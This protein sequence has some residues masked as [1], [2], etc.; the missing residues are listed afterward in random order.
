MSDTAS[1][2]IN[3]I[4]ASRGETATPTT[5]TPQAPD[6]LERAI[7][8]R[9]EAP[10]SPL[11]LRIAARDAEARNVTTPALNERVAARD[12][13]DSGVSSLNERIAA[14]EA[15][16]VTETKAATITAKAQDKVNNFGGKTPSPEEAQPQRSMEQAVQEKAQKLGLEKPVP[17]NMSDVGDESIFR[18]IADIPIKTGQG[19]VMGVRMIA[20]A[21]GADNELSQ[22]LRG[23]EDYLGALVSAQSKED[24]A[25]VSRIM[26]EAKNKGVWEQL[27]AGAEA[28]AV[29]PIDLLSN[30]FGTS[31]PIILAGMATVA[32]GGGTVAVGASGVALGGLTGVGV[33]KGSIYDAT[34]EVLLEQGKVTPEQ[35]EKMAVEAQAY[36]GENLDMILTGGALGILASRSGIE[37]G[38]I[39][40]MGKKLAQ[41]LGKEVSRDIAE[42]T[43]KEGGKSVAKRSALKNIT[44]ETVTEAAQ[45]SHEQLSANVAKNRIGIDTPLME[46]VVSSG[47]LEG[48]GGLGVSGVA[49]AKNI[50]GKT[51][52]KSVLNLDKK[53]K[54]RD[55]KK[56]EAVANGE[57]PAPAGTIKQELKNLK[58]DVVEK[59]SKA[60]QT[61]TSQKKAV[62]ALKEPA[63]VAEALQPDNEKFT[64]EEKV[65][66]AT[67]KSRR[68]AA[69][70]SPE[71]IQK[72]QGEVQNALVGWYTEVHT[73]FNELVAKSPKEERSP[74]DQKRVNELFEIKREI[75]AKIKNIIE[76]A[77]D[78]SK[79]LKDFTNAVDDVKKN[80][81]PPDA[82]VRI[83]G[84][85][86][87]KNIPNADLKSLQESDIKLP[88]REKAI[89]DTQIEI[90]NKVEAL[91]KR[92]TSTKSSDYVHMEVVNGTEDNLG[93]KNYLDNI[94]ISV[95]SQ[96]TTTVK[97]SVG[98]F[99]KF[100]K[101]H[102]DKAVD[103]ANTIKLDNANEKSNT[104]ESK[105]ALDKSVELLKT[106]Y[107]WDHEFAGATMNVL[108]LIKDEVAIGEAY[109]TQIQNVVNTGAKS[110]A[111]PTST[112]NTVI[113]DTV[114]SQEEFEQS[115][116]EAPLPTPDD[117]AG[118][119]GQDAPLG[120]SAGVTSP[121]SEV[122][123]NQSP[124]DNAGTS[125]LET[126]S[127]SEASLAESNKTGS[128][129]EDE[130]SLSEGLKTELKES[131][132][133]LKEN[134]EN[135]G[136]ITPQQE[137]LLK[138]SEKRINGLTDTSLKQRLV[139][140][141]T[142]TATAT[143]T[144]NGAT[145]T[146]TRP[147]KKRAEGQNNRLREFY[148][149]IE[150]V[151]KARKAIAKKQGRRKVTQYTPIEAVTNAII[152]SGKK[153]VMSKK[154]AYD[155]INNKP[156]NKEI[157]GLFVSEKA[158]SKMNP[159]S[160]IDA[161]DNLEPDIFRDA[162]IEPEMDGN[163]VKASWLAKVFNEGTFDV[164]EGSELAADRVVEEEIKRIEEF[165][166]VTVGTDVDAPSVDIIE[167]FRNYD[168]NLEGV[169]QEEAS[170]EEDDA[171]VQEDSLRESDGTNK[172]SDTTLQDRLMEDTGALF[173]S[174][175]G[176]PVHVKDNHLKKLFKVKELKNSLN[177]VLH[178]IVSWAEN[179]TEVNSK[180]N[181]EEKAM[182][183][184][185]IAFDKGINRIL[186]QGTFT[187]ED[188][189]TTQTHSPLLAANEGRALAFKND[190][191][192]NFFYNKEY[193]KENPDTD[194]P[195]L[196]PNMVTAMSSVLY[197]WLA[198]HG[199]G[200][201]SMD[202]TTV[203]RTIMG[204]GNSKITP[205]KEMF[206]L[207]GDKGTNQSLLAEQLGT[208]LISSLGLSVSENNP[209][210]YV[211][212]AAV[213][214]GNVILAAGFQ[215]GMIE[216]T[217]VFT[218]DVNKLKEEYRLAVKEA[219]GT[220]KKVDNE[221]FDEGDENSDFTDFTDLSE[222]AAEGQVFYV[223]V[224]PHTVETKLGSKI[225][226]SP[227]IQDIRKKYKGGQRAFHNLFGSVSP[228]RAPSFEKPKE[229]TV[230]PTIKKTDLNVA[231]E[232]QEILHKKAQEPHQ[233]SDS[234]GVIKDFSDAELF[235]LFGGI[236]DVDKKQIKLQA[237]YNA[238]NTE[239]N[240]F[241]EDMR[242]FIDGAPKDDS[243]NL[244]KDFYYDYEIWRNS[245]IGMKNN[246]MNYQSSKLA[247]QLVALKS[248]KV[249]IPTVNEDSNNTDM[250]EILTLFHMAVAQGMGIDEGLSSNEI[251][252][253]LEELMS[254]KGL[255]GGIIDL[256]VQQEQ[257]Y[258]L[259]PKDRARLIKAT[260]KGGLHKISA[261]TAWA[262]Y[263]QAKETGSSFSTNL[264]RE[265]DGKVNG[266]AHASFQSTFDQEGNP[267]RTNFMNK[268][269]I[270]RNK[271][272][273]KTSN[274]YFNDPKNKDVYQDVATVVGANVTEAGNKL[275]KDP[276]KARAYQVHQGA[277]GLVGSFFEVIDG[278]NTDTVTKDGREF[279]KD[280]VI[281]F[282]YGAEIS[283][284]TSGVVAV[285]MNKLYTDIENTLG[286][287]AKLKIINNS[288][289]NI[290]GKDAKLNSDNY[291]TY[292]LNNVS[293]TAER[294][295]REALANTYKE[296]LRAALNDTFWQIKAAKKKIVEAHQFAYE[297]F[298]GAYYTKAA[299][300]LIGNNGQPLT[301]KQE[302][303]ILK[304]LAPLLP[305]I[306]TAI[307]DN[308]GKSGAYLWTKELTKDYDRV[309][310]QKQ[311][312]ALENS[313]RDPAEIKIFVAALKKGYKKLKSN[314][315]TRNEFFARGSKE[316]IRNTGYESRLNK[317][318]ED[319]VGKLAGFARHY[320]IFESTN[321][322]FVN[323]IH[324]LDS[325]NMLEIYAELEAM[326]IHDAIMVPLN[327]EIK[328]VAF[329]NQ[330]FLKVNNNYNLRAESINR[331]E[332]T[333][334][335]YEKL[336][337]NKNNKKIPYGVVVT[338]ARIAA[339]KAWMNEGAK[340]S[341]FGPKKQAAA[342][343]KTIQKDV[344]NLAKNGLVDQFQAN[345][346]SYS[347]N[348]DGVAQGESI[349]TKDLDKATAK[350]QEKLEKKVD[351]D[352]AIGIITEFRRIG[353][354]TKAGIKTSDQSAD[355]QIY[356]GI[357]KQDLKQ[358]V[359]VLKSSEEGKDFLA[360]DFDSFLG[361]GPSDYDENNFNPNK[362]WE[363]NGQG[364]LDLF[365]ML[366]TKGFGNKPE[367]AEHSKYLRDL[368]VSFGVTESI[369]N[370][371]IKLEET[372]TES[373]GY[374]VTR[375]NGKKEIHMLSASKASANGIRMSVQETYAHELLHILSESVINTS[376]KARAELDRLFNE[377]R[378]DPTVD[379]RA[380]LND[381][382]D[383]SNQAE[384]D[385]AKARYDYIFENTETRQE[386][387]RDDSTGEIHTHDRN[388]FLHEFFALGLSNENFVKALAGRFSTKETKP[389]NK[390]LYDKVVHILVKTMG[391]FDKKYNDIRKDNMS[392]Q[393][394]FIAKR[395]LQNKEVSKSK[396]QT[397][398]AITQQINEQVLYPAVRF[399]IGSIK[400][401][402][403]S[404]YV[405]NNKN[406][407]VRDVGE[408][409]DKAQFKYFSTYFAFLSD[410]RKRMGI[411][412]NNILSSM[413]REV[414]GTTFGMRFWHRMLILSNRK[415]DQNH[416]AVDN[417]V[418]AEALGAYL[419]L[420]EAENVSITKGGIRTDF[421]VLDDSYTLAEIA[422][423]YNTSN[424]AALNS[425]IQSI[426]QRLQNAYDPEV[427]NFYWKMSESLAN[428]MVEGRALEED[429][430]GS[431]YS[432]VNMHGAD[433]EKTVTHEDI[434][435]TERLIDILTTLNAIKKTSDKTKNDLHGVMLRENARGDVEGGIDF[436][437][438][439]LKKNK[440]EALNNKELFN[441]NKAE[442]RKGFSKE[443]YAPNV[444]FKYGTAEEE[445]E[446]FK[447][448]FL[449]ISNKSHGVALDAAH[450]AEKRIMYVNT[451]S[452]ITTFQRGIVAL[453]QEATIGTNVLDFNSQR[454]NNSVNKAAKDVRNIQAAKKA[455]K[456]KI[457]DSAPSRVLDTDANNLLIP[458]NAPDGT[459]TGYR[460]IM[461]E[462]TKDE[463]LNRD[464]SFEKVLGKMEAGIDDK[465]NA[466]MINKK[467]IKGL[468][469][470][471]TTMFST[472]T[473]NHFVKLGP[474][475][476]NPR[477]K[478]IWQMMPEPMRRE[479]KA[480]W[481]TDG[482]YVREE[483]VEL[484]FGRRKFSIA[485]YGRESV[486]A[487]NKPG[488]INHTLGM[489]LNR[490]NVRRVE[491]FV[492]DLVKI[493]KDIIVI[494]SVAVLIDNVISNYVILLMRG[495][496][497]QDIFKYKKEALIDAK[498][499]KELLTK[500][501]TLVQ[502]IALKEQSR[503]S[504]GAPTKTV[505][506]AQIKKIEGD[507]TIVR[508]SIAINAVRDLSEA[509]VHQ[510]IVEDVSLEDNDNRLRGN[511]EDLITP[512]KK[513]VP[514]IVQGGLKNVFLTR[515]TQMYKALRDVTQMSD[516]VGRYALHQHN[517]KV[518]KMKREDSIE[519]IFAA[520]IHYDLPTHKGIQY[521]NDVGIWMFTKFFFRIQ[522]E[523]FRSIFGAPNRDG[524]RRA[525]NPTASAAVLASQIF[526]G[527][528]ADIYESGVVT[529]SGSHT[530]D[531]NILHTIYKNLLSGA[532]TSAAVSY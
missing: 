318:S 193:D 511:I 438:K 300:V 177:N 455:N 162:G 306:D 106:K 16:T 493:I 210:N 67:D 326:G 414:A 2:Q 39:T 521:L 94:T 52:A 26:E 480:V 299:N 409:I 420:T 469:T 379:Y 301:I 253:E 249:D 387:I 123:L 214:L 87:G 96:E 303:D 296:P 272:Q 359:E 233:M 20:D 408:I 218:E 80:S 131:L 466:R 285:S 329:A 9:P 61:V 494:K 452:E 316:K 64:K 119:S 112:P 158:A 29:A 398:N 523:I 117:Y 514:E 139:E 46:G 133:A 221:D 150:Y 360:E 213:D 403:R 430:F 208:K 265:I 48:L 506:D 111:V 179:Y 245:R 172:P 199:A 276:K 152:N 405:K 417:H 195:L 433:Y 23:V 32:S 294:D 295:V 22:S 149:D 283:S 336:R 246:I 77:R 56:A 472:A 107:D 424:K 212:K 460:Y 279:A 136:T 102:K 418:R 260:A 181:D 134:K 173:K 264:T 146:K 51:A 105:A 30:A 392:N 471:Y 274:E 357:H 346:T 321:K 252:G 489:L 25:E 381:P 532:F 335:A 217:V 47:V 401:A 141:N 43:I 127:L 50:V 388:D 125:G 110:T 281:K 375:S 15:P 226:P 356:M 451:N 510:T 242:F 393:L 496:S 310:M 309:H 450:V 126:G 426:M 220:K 495:M 374:A 116:Q 428:V 474:D 497:I 206:D 499:Y 531:V 120:E 8:R 457:F 391:L 143:A 465:I 530:F 518:M 319:G 410:V 159:D 399:V 342:S 211:S 421:S 1:A 79:T 384:N 71:E 348:V 178:N 454:G 101:G 190:S 332:S 373:A 485:D 275:K 481:G 389:D 256:L 273:Y 347:D 35:A 250:S 477:Y 180:L 186:T 132:A 54:E 160:L 44:E 519:D 288:L 36:D 207:L 197:E 380:F 320:E 244:T 331:L 167:A 109:S 476:K 157:R 363:V 223:R 516:F 435:D 341:D 406:R 196:D 95:E 3:N 7:A 527:D 522:K 267:V 349:K 161:A 362:I 292:E 73:E 524:S 89:L 151:K 174:E 225:L 100:L 293:I 75:G 515:D 487:G 352:T 187:R 243:G 366:G 385:A 509:G 59:F 317:G 33:T 183:K 311:I 501:S 63:K 227:Y 423:F 528:F 402:A 504:K 92:A 436:T 400:G 247:R 483:I 473:P 129:T 419:E 6:A 192:I 340:G 99:N 124:P 4:L 34:K 269:G 130:T 463:I 114:I 235:E 353:G 282:I 240:K 529:G 462:S 364:A 42:G 322:A 491:A 13:Q 482:I 188:G 85:T 176:K 156:T 484:V 289:S 411:S 415:M 121:T 168:N 104:E 308:S 354:S 90:N 164:R 209:N 337:D 395:L 84:S 254:P 394:K 118:T 184:N 470:E 201:L 397:F 330:A 228:D 333:I 58:N 38:L 412:A 219:D 498:K 328:D 171:G 396:V 407:V 11:D 230:S 40:G 113:D 445:G 507:L 69:D 86:G 202:S 103:F 313:G 271:K 369:D 287:P 128:I 251:I 464:N 448:G 278:K 74:A 365:D 339:M 377:V 257:G 17:I 21:M 437:M 370:L 270:F 284:I 361:S 135:G 431:A 222:S 170:Q 302:E 248:M 305:R 467:V 277:L 31:V 5:D 325:M 237:K 239:I 371:I 259:E 444:T 386:S 82:I 154:G 280:P 144:D 91:E 49:D 41:R 520:F 203:A 194:V 140:A 525:G 263:M 175:E 98:N 500:E 434:N 297:L 458:I 439:L 376:S 334:E 66:L 27:K 10:M 147:L 45:G 307:S 461:K 383:L 358:A 65:I 446:M 148:K 350:D 413:F 327:T 304:E 137:Q 115:N 266:V 258:E 78:D 18:E 291:L 72:Y 234:F 163:Y 165:V 231:E 286:D 443:L 205:T 83:L 57:E 169:V 367:N 314:S 191:L 97:K 88:E 182:V 526:V 268:T 447:D 449:P 19:A 14:R 229:N 351:M 512:A 368:L 290:L 475:S 378:D 232:I 492:Q 505:I 459:I 145:T 517:T 429:T 138:L 390:T 12:A 166:T 108:K 456:K 324:S 153:I 261:I 198:V 255:Y 440:E 76:V 60:K 323:G 155:K 432:I 24:S 513:F 70:A 478:E 338:P 122:P 416:K 204:S 53:L 68:P 238:Q 93:F 453:Q 262:K 503:T 200:T 488:M 345:H 216:R 502:K 490:P 468:H 344:T 298:E 479:I 442:V 382:N 142:A 355:A 62:D 236:N 241:I 372:G 224:K 343:Q 312:A 441:G 422:E 81:S 425:E 189:V 185:F 404:K 315:T 55:A 215:S 427:Y 508:E 37:P 28:F 486:K